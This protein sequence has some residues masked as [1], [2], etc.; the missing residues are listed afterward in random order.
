MGGLGPGYEQAIQIL[1]FEI[2]REHLRT[3]KPLPTPQ[4][5]NANGWMDN[6][7]HRINEQLGGFSGAQVGA[8]KNL[9][10]HYLKDG[11]AKSLEKCKDRTIQVS[12]FFPK[13]PPVPGACHAS[14]DAGEQEK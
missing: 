2:L 3:K 4:S 7:I 5:A 1:V 12:R 13:A 6:V 11:Y 14:T 8:A 10:Y 9:A